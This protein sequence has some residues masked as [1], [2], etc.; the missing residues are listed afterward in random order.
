[1][2]TRISGKLVGLNGVEAA[3]D[4]G[5]FEYEVSVPDFVRRQLQSQIG[6]PITL[7]TI[8]YLDG[9]PQK[10]RLVPKIGGL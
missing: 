2:I 3:I 9:N 5:A 6:Q 1:M 10:G 7:R 4:I 8:E